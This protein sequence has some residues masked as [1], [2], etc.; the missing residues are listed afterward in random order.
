MSI[1][2][3]D[4]LRTVD[5]HAFRVLATDLPNGLPT[6]IFVEGFGTYMLDH[7]NKCPANP[8]M[9][10]VERPRTITRFI[11]MYRAADGGICPGSKTY[12]SDAQRL[13]MRDTAR[14][15]FGLRIEY[16]DTTGRVTAIKVS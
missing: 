1:T 15:L 14:A 16:D 9:S 11:N 13:S 10:L 12:E 4:N 5:G 3:F 7:S 6:I 8:G 2:R